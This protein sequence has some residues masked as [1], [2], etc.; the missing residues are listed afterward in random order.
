MNN[1]IFDWYLSRQKFI[2]RPLP[3]CNRQSPSLSESKCSKLFEFL[4]NS[5]YTTIVMEACED[6]HYM[7]RKFSEMRHKTKLIPPHFVQPFVKINKNDFFEAETICE[8]TSS[9]Q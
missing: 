6:A 9:H 2:Q 3:R 1:V 8:V 4:T 5:S 7:A